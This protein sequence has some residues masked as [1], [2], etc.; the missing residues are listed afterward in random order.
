MRRIII[1]TDPGQDDA[2]A[3]MLALAAPGLHVLGLVTVAGNVP[4][5]Q[6]TA[7]ACRILEL[8][9]RRD[10]GVYAGCAR[11][12]RRVPITAAHVHG[13]TGMDGPALP[14]PT[15]RAQARHGVDFLIETVR[16]HPPGSITLVTLGR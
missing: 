13:R 9:Q 1:D 10:I 11:P 2:I 14:A 12:L 5:E 16:A 3:I 6:T 15:L 4:V 8:A 7:N